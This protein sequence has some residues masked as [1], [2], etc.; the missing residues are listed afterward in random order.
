[1]LNDAKKSPTIDDVASL[2]GVSYQT[3]SRVVNQH[4]SVSPKTRAKVQAAIKSLGYQPNNVARSLASRRSTSLGLISFGTAFYGPAQMVGNLE[5]TARQR[6]YS[7]SLASITSLTLEELT[8]AVHT[9]LRQRV[10]GMLVIAPLQAVD[11]S[12]LEQL[13]PDLPL[14]LIDAEPTTQIPFTSIDQY[15]GARQAAQ[16]LLELGHSQIAFIGG[17][18]DWHDALERQRG[19]LSALREAGL[20]PVAQ[21]E[22]D[23]ST[24][25]GY[26]AAQNLLEQKRPFT[27]LLIANDQMALGALLALSEAGLEVPQQ[28]SVVGFDNIPESAFFQPPLTTVQ[29]DF[30]ALAQQSLQQLLALIETPDSAPKAQR[31]PTQLIVRKSTAECE[32]L[33]AKH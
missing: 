21:P 23:W 7:L 14:V 16:H 22:G 6:G 29:Q 27:A 19:W 1:M 11:S 28:V 10:D 8:G 32:T 24:A 30:S 15:G 33:K 2:A 3:V 31:I 5:Q 18:A 13:C 26:Q 25:S 4:P 12:R 9:L 17:P 20:K